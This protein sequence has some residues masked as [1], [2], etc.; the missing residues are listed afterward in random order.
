MFVQRKI[1]EAL[2]GTAQAD[3]DMWIGWKSLQDEVARFGPQ[4]PY[5]VLVPT[6]KDVD[7]DDVF[8]SV[9]YEKGFAFLHYLQVGR[10]CARCHTP[11]CPPLIRA[12]ALQH[13]VGGAPVFNRFMRAYVDK[14]KFKTLTADEF[15]HYFL[16]YFQ[17]V[18]C[19]Q[20]D[21]DAWYFAPGM[22][23]VA[24][25]FGT[26]LKHKCN[27]LVDLWVAGGRGAAATDMKDWSPL[28]V[29]CFLDELHSRTAERPLSEPTVKRM[30]ELYGLT[31]INTPEIK[32]RWQRVCLAAGAEWIFPHVTQ[33][34]AQQGRMKV[35]H[36][37][38]YC[39]RWWS[40]PPAHVASSLLQYVRPLYRELYAQPAGKQLAV[41]TFRR[42]RERYHPI[43]TKMI[44]VDLGEAKPEAEAEA[45]AAE[46]E[47]AA[48]A[49]SLFPLPPS[50]ARLAGCPQ[51]RRRVLVAAA[52]AT[53]AMGSVLAFRRFKRH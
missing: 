42:E 6:L 46:S 2:H 11:A 1:V 34:V 49:C 39:R 3:L 48:C 17:H 47:A 10:T 38:R 9:P 37:C 50:L 43:A 32:F 7:P 31:R 52:V 22:P 51:V 41:H 23:P 53:L 30:D 24:P 28:M 13:V 8:S 14:F 5:T 19:S 21:W 20:I 15:K 16:S 4:H 18:N 36:C 40:P 25:T 12:C 26:E 35:R 33:F 27:A 45:E 29:Q 44:A